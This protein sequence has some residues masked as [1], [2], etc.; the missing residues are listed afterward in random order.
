MIVAGALAA[1]TLLFAPLVDGLVRT[2]ALNDVDHRALVVSLDGRGRPCV[3]HVHGSM[4][5]P[6]YLYPGLVP[7]WWADRLR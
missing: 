7:G 4:C 5:W 6:W 2:L 3:A 1:L